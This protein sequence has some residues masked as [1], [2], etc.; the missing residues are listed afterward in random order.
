MGKW[1]SSP[2][3]PLSTADHHGLMTTTSHHPS[4]RGIREASPWGTSIRGENGTRALTL[5]TATGLEELQSELEQ[6]RERDRQDMAQGLRDARATGGGSNNDEYHAV[7]EE[8]MVTAARI[9][10]LEEIVERAVV[11]DPDAAGEGVAVIGA[12]VLVEDMTSGAKRRYRLANAHALEPD[13]VSAASP[14]GQALMGATAGEVVTLDLP[15]GS[16]RSLRL[17]AVDPPASRS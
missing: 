8:Q 13:A 15:N 14:M 16:S 12:S 1:A 5:M 10:M 11:V 6:L 2:I 3:P 9:A 17:V 4:R 7:L